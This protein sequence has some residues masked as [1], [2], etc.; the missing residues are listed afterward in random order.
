[1]TEAL[2]QAVLAAVALYLVVETVIDLVRMMTAAAR[3]KSGPE[4][5]RVVFDSLDEL[6]EYVRREVAAQQQLAVNQAELDRELA[7][8]GNRRRMRDG[9]P[10]PE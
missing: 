2:W 1:M 6:A 10:V 9:K 4:T 3:R 5:T 7:A 8:L